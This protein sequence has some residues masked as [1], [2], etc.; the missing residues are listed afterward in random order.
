MISTE[1]EGE[2]TSLE[3]ADQVRFHIRAI[4]RKAYRDMVMFGYVSAEHMEE[5]ELRGIHPQSAIRVIKNY[6]NGCEEMLNN[7]MMPSIDHLYIFL[8]D[9]ADNFFEAR[10]A[11]INDDD[12]TR[13]YLIKDKLILDEE[14]EQEE[15]S[16]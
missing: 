16:E 3:S 10:H 9:M 14:N 2:L 4:F 13:N 1:M 5:L 7:E 12:P 11:V 8:D 6:M 15:A